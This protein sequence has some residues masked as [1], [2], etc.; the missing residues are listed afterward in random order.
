MSDSGTPWIVACQ[1][2]S[3]HGILQP[4]ILEWVIMPF[5]DLPDSGIQP[6]FLMAPALVGGLVPPGKP[7]FLMAPYNICIPS[8]F[9]REKAKILVCAKD[10][11]DSAQFR[12][13][14]K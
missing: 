5:R 3:V 11:L 8:N 2:S 4:R 14:L 9:H 1:T 12:I 13:T 6:A 10:F 7:L